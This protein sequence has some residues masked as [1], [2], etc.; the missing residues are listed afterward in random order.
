MELAARYGSAALAVLRRDLT[1]FASYRLRL[2][3]QATAT[4][5]SLVVFYY[6][7]RL[8]RVEFFSSPDE[9]FAFVV[10][11]LVILGVLTS[12]LGSAPASMRQELVAGTFERLIVSPFGAVAGVLSMMLFPFLYALL[13]GLVTLLM[14]GVVFDLPVRWST[15][16]LALP[17]AFLGLLSFA[18]FAVAIAAGVLVFK[19]FSSASSFIVAGIS[20]AAGLYFPV[21]LLPAWIE[22]TAEVQPF[23]P[24][25][26][27]LR[28]VLVGT[29]L[30]EP[31]W[32]EVAKLVGFAAVLFPASVLLLRAAVETGRRRGTVIEY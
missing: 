2:V 29:P 17:V 5:F 32:L 21:A 18:P 25:A 8:V 20:I 22:W 13:N 9:Y 10:V 23:T 14:A 26:D 12:T 28:H 16:G 19:Q 11:G 4:L 30:R 27:L 15:A 24:A 31:A 1:I 7:S 6:V 3:A